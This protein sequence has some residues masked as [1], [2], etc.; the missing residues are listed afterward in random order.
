MTGNKPVTKQH[1]YTQ[2]KSLKSLIFV[3]PISE[4]PVQKCRSSFILIPKFLKVSLQWKPD[5]F[6]TEPST[7]KRKYMKNQVAASLL[8]IPF[9]IKGLTYEVHFHRNSIL[10]RRGCCDKPICISRLIRHLKID[11]IKIDFCV[12]LIINFY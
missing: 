12:L 7:I 3:S 6:W 4:V 2:K 5:P 11:K 9:L 10:W 1:F 8:I